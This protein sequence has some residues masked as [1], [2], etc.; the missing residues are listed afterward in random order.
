MVSWGT[1]GNIDDIGEGDFD[2][3]TQLAWYNDFIDGV[4]DERDSKYMVELEAERGVAQI[5]DWE[6]RG[7]IEWFHYTV[8]TITCD[9]DEQVLVSTIV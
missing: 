7:F 6:K 5:Q 8:F 4:I 1:S 3:N 9:P 2:V